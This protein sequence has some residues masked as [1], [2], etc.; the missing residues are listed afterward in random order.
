MT[1]KKKLIENSGRVPAW[2]VRYESDSNTSV[3]P[4]GFSLSRKDTYPICMY[5]SPIGDLL[6]HTLLTV[7]DNNMTHPSIIAPCIVRYLPHVLDCHRTIWYPISPP[8]MPS[9]ASPDSISSDKP[10]EEGCCPYGSTTSTSRTF[11]AIGIEIRIRFD[12]ERS[13]ALC[14]FQQRVHLYLLFWRGYRCIRIWESLREGTN[15][16]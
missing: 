10:K 11:L 5:I 13:R 15:V 1:R 16:T 2:N 9:A 4:P 8:L 3:R 14:L 12:W 6:I 7:R